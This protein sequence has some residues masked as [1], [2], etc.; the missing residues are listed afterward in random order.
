MQKQASQTEQAA[1]AQSCKHAATA[2]PHTQATAPN[3]CH[4]TQQTRLQT[5]LRRCLKRS[6]Q[7][8]PTEGHINAAQQAAPSRTHSTCHLVPPWAVTHQ[9]GKSYAPP[10]C[11]SLSSSSMHSPT[12]RPHTSPTQGLPWRQREG[13]DRFTPGAGPP[14]CAQCAASLWQGP[15]A[16]QGRR[17]P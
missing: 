11:S 5:F 1:A 4:G 2:G 13:G 9:T 10:C 3:P 16:P 6:Y 7:L 12:A 14:A 17:R 15:R 8:T